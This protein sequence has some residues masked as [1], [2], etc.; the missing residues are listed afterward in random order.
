MNS[1]LL[2]KAAAPVRVLA[3]TRASGRPKLGECLGRG[4]R[5]QKASFCA[6]S[7]GRPALRHNSAGPASKRVG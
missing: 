4:A 6:E 2:L 3:Q 7:H 5:L 1:G